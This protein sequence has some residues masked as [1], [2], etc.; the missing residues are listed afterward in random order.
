[1]CKTWFVA[2]RDN[3]ANPI[4]HAL[5]ERADCQALAMSEVELWSN[6]RQLPPSG[7]MQ[8][9]LLIVDLQSTDQ[10]AGR[11]VG[12]LSHDNP[13]AA[14]IAI[15][16]AENPLL[17]DELLSFGVDEILIRPVE[18]NQIRRTIEGILQRMAAFDRLLGLQEKLRKEMGRCRIIAKSKPM[19]AIMQRLPQLANSTATVLITGET[20]TGKE[21]IVRAIHYLSSRSGLPFITVDCG[22]MPDHLVENELFGHAR[23]AYTDAS[24]SSKGLIQEADGGTLFLD[25]VETLPLGVQAKF[26]R[27]LQERQYKPLGQSKYVSVDVRIMAATNV[28]LAQAVAKKIFREDLYYR[29][30]VIPLFI[31]PL[32]E[33]KADIPALAHAFLQRHAG[34]QHA[35]IPNEILRRW[36]NYD[37]PG[38]VRE[39]E[40]EVQQWLTGAP[41]DNPAEATSFA[42][43]AHKPLDTLAEA[44]K[45]A[46][47][48]CDRTYLQN[49]LSHTKG[50]ISAA[51]RLAG[52]HRKSLSTLLKK[53]GIQ[54]FRFRS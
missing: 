16:P 17:V 19:Q 51:A 23:G 33:R 40:N 52:I 35:A 12:R 42:V 2:S 7:R 22:A 36:M 24:S 26:L 18:E 48:A 46:L 21:L 34:D 41:T 53:Y 39:L 49:L 20:G 10:A 9:N 30:N 15:V 6:S 47:T 4:N 50:N 3:L 13:E 37:W 8:P 54:A 38:N 43:T 11:L 5:S 31:P 44:R 28:D 29:L 45:K 25:E 27:F 32:R 14:I 1:M